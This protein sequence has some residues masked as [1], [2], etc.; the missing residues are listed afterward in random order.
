MQPTTAGLPAVYIIILSSILFNHKQHTHSGQM[1]LLLKF[2][3]N[4]RT[5]TATTAEEA[6]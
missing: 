4:Y 6:L 5:T 1:H 2:K 3:S